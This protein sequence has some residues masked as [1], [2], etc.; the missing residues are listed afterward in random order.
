MG[1]YVD[2]SGY[3]DMCFLENNNGAQS[4]TECSLM[5]KNAGWKRMKRISDGEM[6]HVCPTCRVEHKD[7]LE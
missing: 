7:E 1:F 4:K 5:L 3:C 2:I 6:I